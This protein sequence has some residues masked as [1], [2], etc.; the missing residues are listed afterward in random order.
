MGINYVYVEK[1]IQDL[2][3]LFENG[4]L[5]LEPGYQRESVWS[6]K[7]RRKLIET[8]IQKYP[9]PSVFLYRRE[10][11]NGDLKYDVID[12]KQRLE[13]IFMFQGLGKF[14]RAR[15]S[16]QVKRDATR[17]VEDWDWKKMQQKRCQK[18]LTGY[19]IPIVEVFSDDLSN[20]EELFVLINSTGKKLAGP[21]LRNA[22]FYRSEFLRDAG[23]LAKRYENYFLQ[24]RI[25][26]RN[27][28]TR[29]KHIE[30]ICELVA[31]IGSPGGLINKKKTLD[32]IIGGQTIKGR[33]LQKCVQEF[34]H[35]LNRVKA[36]FPNIR[37]TRFA[38]AVDFYSLF[39]LVWEMEK[40]NCI[41]TDSRRNRQAEK[42]LTWLS[43][44]VDQVRQQNRKIEGIEPGQRLFANY[45]LTVQGDTD[46]SATRQRRAEI[47][48]Q[49]LGGLFEKKDSQRLFT[50]EQRRLIWNSGDQKRCVECG[51]LLTW[52][53]F[54]IDHIKS[55]ASG[56][57]TTISNSA[58]M[59]RKHNSALGA[60]LRRRKTSSSL[61]PRR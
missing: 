19:Q 39:M 2:V 25:L 54:T 43:N 32:D 22:R 36:M 26:S 50:P 21:E 16:V 35:T 45:L 18:I 56:G 15:F 60:K 11:S 44:G 17:E 3:Y 8:I 47:L 6:P 46:S 49:V 41:L 12:G 55:H 33:Q 7:D 13:S 27:Q 1:T 20:V 4:H 9:L 31:S 40:Q 29:R 53:N 52:D 59:C 23:K 61:K 42:L 30:L 5:N 57:R 51:V 34:V 38:N 10:D 58:L 14:R 24:N 37:S 48:H 28:I